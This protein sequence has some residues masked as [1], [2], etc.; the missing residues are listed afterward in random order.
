MYYILYKEKKISR[1]TVLPLEGDMGIYCDIDTDGKEPL[2]F[3]YI[4]DVWRL[5]S[6]LSSLGH[7]EF[8]FEIKYCEV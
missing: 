5:L 2:Y 7:E 1:V 8:W 6:L 4:S 3:E